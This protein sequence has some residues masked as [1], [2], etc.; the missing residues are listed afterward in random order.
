MADNIVY[1]SGSYVKDT[2]AKISIFDRG[3]T[4]C[5]WTYDVTRTFNHK[6][7]QLREHI[8]RLYRSLDFIQLD[9]GLT[10]D[11]MHDITLEVFRRNEKSLG[12]GDDFSITHRVSRG[13]GEL[14]PGTYR[15]TVAIYCN[16]I[17]FESFAQRL[18][19]GAPLVVVSTRRVPPVCM[20]PKAK[21]VS[22][23]FLLANLEGQSVDPSAWVLMLDIYGFLSECTSKNIFLVRKGALFTP[24]RDN[25]LEGVTR[26]TVLELASKHDVPCTETDLSVYDLMTA[27]EVFVT[28]VTPVMIPISKINNKLLKNPGPGPVIRKLQRAWSELVGVDIV[29]QALSH[30]DSSMPAGRAT[31]PLP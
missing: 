7:F 30:L 25:V 4:N 10:Q 22:L 20:D 31:R 19:D 8:A 12:P 29:A 23:N 15:P 3:F 27:D 16:G 9:P 21:H 17:K 5:D 13:I 24:K 11:E 2:E 18:I 28:S 6:P 14:A 1:L 26:A